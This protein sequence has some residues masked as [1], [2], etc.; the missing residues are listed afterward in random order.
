MRYFKVFAEVP[1]GRG[2]VFYEEIEHLEQNNYPD[3][4]DIN[5]FKTIAL[6]LFPDTSFIQIYELAEECKI[7]RSKK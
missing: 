5:Y 4:A 2:N 1:D 7:H 3:D 6:D